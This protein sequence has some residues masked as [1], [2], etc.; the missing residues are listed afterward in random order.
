MT[1]DV[2]NETRVRAADQAL[3][4]RAR[5]VIANGMYGHLSVNRLDDPLLKQLHF[6]VA[7]ARDA[8]THDGKRV[9][10]PVP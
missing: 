4:E 6:A 2:S 3:R 10:L 5:S 8:V 7:Q 1:V 9:P